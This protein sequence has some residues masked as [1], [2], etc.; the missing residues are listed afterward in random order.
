[1]TVQRNCPPWGS[2]CDNTAC[3]RTKIARLTKKI[4][5][6]FSQTGQPKPKT[7]LSPVCCHE[8]SMFRQPPVRR[9]FPVPVE[10]LM[11]VEMQE[12]GLGSAPPRSNRKI[13]SLRSP[14][15]AG[16]K[17]QPCDINQVVGSRVF[18]GGGSIEHGP[19][20]FLRPPA[21]FAEPFKR[22]CSPSLWRVCGGLGPG[23][24]CRCNTHRP[25]LSGFAVFAGFGQP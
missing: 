6:L 22:S 20:P 11:P 12:N 4:R 13:A 23:I 25:P 19:K 9:R 24:S 3:F 5:F 15:P 10:A 18:T 7:A 2:P 8:K 16:A 21:R 1:M 17:K 14:R